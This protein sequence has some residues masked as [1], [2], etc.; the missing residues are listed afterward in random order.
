MFSCVCVFARI[1]FARVLPVDAAARCAVFEASKNLWRLQ[2]AGP[3]VRVRPP[4][5]L[6][7]V[8]CSSV[9]CTESRQFVLVSM[10][11]YPKGTL[12][13]SC[14]RKTANLE[15][16]SG[17]VC[18]SGLCQC[19]GEIRSWFFER[20]ERTLRRHTRATCSHIRVL[21][22]QHVWFAPTPRACVCGFN[23]MFTTG[24]RAEEHSRWNAWRKSSKRSRRLCARISVSLPRASQEAA[25]VFCIV[26]AIE[27]CESEKCLSVRNTS[28]ASVRKGNSLQ[29]GQVTTAS[30]SGALCGGPPQVGCWIC[31]QREGLWQ[32]CS[33]VDKRL[34]SLTIFT[35]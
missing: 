2:S 4:V 30:H 35:P 31:L 15:M 33:Q 16:A 21:L 8:F 29:H 26:S 24:D 28:A 5:I 20:K 13:R 6:Q 10:P 32:R 7:C 19:V 12:Y 34:V 17:V 25:Q 22:A 14:H 3:L 1:M 11:D 9:F 27:V 23:R 18:Q